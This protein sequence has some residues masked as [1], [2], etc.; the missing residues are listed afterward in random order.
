LL[1][2]QRVV[3]M[4]FCFI[5][6]AMRKV[7]LLRRA[8]DALPLPLFIKDDRGR[9]VYAN[10]ARLKLQKL[11][12]LDELVGKTAADFYAP[13][14]AAKLLETDRRVLAEAYEVHDNETAIID[15]TGQQRWM[16]STKIPL[17]DDSG[18]VV[19]L[20]GIMRDVTLQRRATDQLAYQANYDTLTGLVNRAGF[21]RTLSEAVDR[22][23]A[24]GGVGVAYV[25]VDCFK[26]INDTMGH[27]AGDRVLVEVAQ[28]LTVG[29][30]Q[31]DTVARLGGDEFVVL[32]R[33]IGQPQDL[34]LAGQRLLSTLRPPIVIDGHELCVTCSVGV[35]LL[36]AGD[37]T[38]EDL[39][40][41]A[42]QAMYAAKHA[43]RDRLVG[44]YR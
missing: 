2:F 25:D 26:R 32:L 9:Y 8:L 44:Q 15:E 35:A 20:V 28:R 18:V 22:A 31:H 5:T 27:E 1:F 21:M 43:G 38:A 10:A 39:L 42:D 13:D 40:R 17:I 33:H 34:E 16:Q 11:G 4:A 37:S 6:F 30:R 29:V 41:S 7:S 3:I 36:R 24:L 19:G 23:A 14:V 12:S